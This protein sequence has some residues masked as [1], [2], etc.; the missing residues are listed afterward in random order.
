MKIQ[1]FSSSFFVIL[2][3]ILFSSFAQKQDRITTSH[4]GQSLYYGHFKGKIGKEIISMDLIQD[5]ENYSGSYSVISSNVLVSLD[6]KSTSS[7]EIKLK[8]SSSD[9]NAIG[10]ITGKISK[11]KF[12]GTFQNEDKTQ[13]HSIDL[14][15]DYSKSL[16]FS[17]TSIKD[18]IKRVE[19]EERK[20]NCFFSDTKMEV[21]RVPKKIN[22]ITIN[23]L[24]DDLQKSISFENAKKGMINDKIEFFKEYENV[25]TTK[26]NNERQVE[27]IFNDNYFTTFLFSHSQN[28][29]GAHGAYKQNCLVIDVKNAKK[30]NLSDIFDEKG[31][32]DVEEKIKKRA[33]I[34]LDSEDTVSL[35]EAGYWENRIIPTE[36]FL[37]TAQ[38]ITFMYQEYEICSFV[39]GRPSFFFTWEE[40][41]DIIKVDASVRSLIKK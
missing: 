3:L 40:L 18:T 8:T 1:I 6:G 20:S 32:I 28:M 12:V 9:K 16:D 34:Y 14:I 21:I 27:I 13:N 38:G 36:N 19:D 30:I 4:K 39:M 15:E 29:G 5:L 10:Y 26:W 25:S 11:N 37:L 17:L 22:L 2:L 31:L 33:Y 7:G 24:V 41:K 35:R 23:R